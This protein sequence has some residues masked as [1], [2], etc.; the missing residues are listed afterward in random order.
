MIG[1]VA[2][3]RGHWIQAV[4]I[5]VA[6]HGA[7]AA[8]MMDVLPS[9]PNRPQDRAL[10]EIDILSLPVEQGTPAP[11]TLEPAQPVEAA[12]A[13][14]VAP[15][16]ITPATPDEPAAEVEQPILTPA[17]DMREATASTTQTTEGEQP[18]SVQ[19]G[20]VDQAVQVAGLP[21]SMLPGGSASPPEASG[22][23]QGSAAQ[24][25]AIAQ[26]VQQLRAQLGQ[27]CLA[28]LPQTIGGEEVMLTVLGADDRDIADLF[29]DVAGGVEVPMTERS[30]LLDAR[31]CPAV[32]FARSSAT[33]PA[34][35]LV[36][37]LQASEVA[38][39][40]RLIGQIEGAGDNQTT[41]LLV[42]DNGVVQ[43]LRRFT[44]QAGDVIRFDVPVYRVGGDRDTSQLL[45]AVALPQRPTSITDLAGQLASD[46]FPP[47][48]DA[49]NGQALIGITPV[50]VRA[51][52]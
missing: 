29:R 30:V 31:Q 28:A 9:L 48:S 14:Q 20:A 5:S 52:P 23:P 39:D 46:F 2:E 27:P 7:A 24:N 15:A 36:L 25:G 26:L 32:D 8:A 17:D 19:P 44:L 49:A 34:M 33:Y 40:D 3:K 22:L 11:V 38:S 18:D 16:A 41:L 45:M 1:R 10:P 12:A 50:Y 37:R 21:P 42:D 51:A 35:P 6:L 4:V 13:S 47:L 43:D